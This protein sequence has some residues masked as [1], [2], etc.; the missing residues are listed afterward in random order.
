ML[1]RHEK[2]RSLKKHTLA[3]TFAKP[4]VNEVTKR[5]ALIAESE[6][7]NITPPFA[8]VSLI[9]SSAGCREISIHEVEFTA[10]ADFEPAQPIV[11]QNNLI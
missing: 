4:H 11:K 3:M 10:R 5:V 8:V 7:M 1:C 6:G 2:V 9:S